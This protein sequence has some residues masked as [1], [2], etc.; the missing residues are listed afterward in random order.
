MRPL[1]RSLSVTLLSYTAPETQTVYRHAGS[2]TCVA[3]ALLT[4]GTVV[5]VTGGTDNTARIWNESDGSKLWFVQ[6]LC[7]E[8]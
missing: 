7:L 6:P 2:V 4:D 5:V 8:P 3:F 1:S